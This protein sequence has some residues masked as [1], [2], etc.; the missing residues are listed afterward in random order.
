MPVGLIGNFSS[1]AVKED[2]LLSQ[3]QLGR[4]DSRV[5]LFL[6]RVA[7]IIPNYRGIARRSHVLTNLKLL[8]RE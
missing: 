5:L 2:Q 3:P 8:L 7:L 6:G 4:E 1:P